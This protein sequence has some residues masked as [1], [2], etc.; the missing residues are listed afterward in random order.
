MSI[1][2]F[3]IG[4][5]SMDDCSPSV[6]VS[7][8]AFIIINEIEDILKCLSFQTSLRDIVTTLSY[9][10]DDSLGTGSN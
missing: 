4:S 2:V 3:Y 7:R 8:C 10:F 1:K 9:G 5:V 6:L